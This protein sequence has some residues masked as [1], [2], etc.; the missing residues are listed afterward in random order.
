MQKWLLDVWSHFGCSVLMVTHDIE[1]AVWM[2]DRVYV[3]S[4]SP[5][6]IIAEKTIPFPRP[7]V[8]HIRV[9]QDFLEMKTELTILLGEEL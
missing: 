5:G 3:M 6:R 4:S 2:S 9:Q 8:P 7:R 1:E